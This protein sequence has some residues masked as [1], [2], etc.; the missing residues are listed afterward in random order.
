MSNKNSKMKI[1]DK[2]KLFVYGT[3]K[4]GH[5]LHSWLDEAQFIRKG[6]VHGFTLYSNGSYPI[7][8]LEE[9]G[10]I[11]GEIYQVDEK[12]TYMQEEK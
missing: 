10:C 3:L 7:A 11:E 1:P 6:E 12:T 2:L 5:R 8:V 9:N 4:E